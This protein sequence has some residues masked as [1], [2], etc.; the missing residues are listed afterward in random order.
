[1]KKLAVV[2]IFVASTAY[3]QTNNPKVCLTFTGPNKFQLFLP[4]KIYASRALAIH[5][6]QN[7]GFVPDETDNDDDWWVKTSDGDLQVL[8]FRYI[9]TYPVIMAVP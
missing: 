9:K 5:D 2:L 1:M 3:T 7:E 6:A 4:P 8:V